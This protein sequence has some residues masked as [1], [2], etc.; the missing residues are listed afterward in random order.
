[1]IE[2]TATG[3]VLMKITIA[4]LSKEG[5]ANLSQF[6]KNNGKH[7]ETK[8]LLWLQFLQLVVLIIPL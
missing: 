8:V 6:E 4:C 1:M 7:R 5:A 2:G 3:N